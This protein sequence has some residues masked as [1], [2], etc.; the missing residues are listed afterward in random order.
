MR[1]YWLSAHWPPEHGTQPRFDIWVQDGHDDVARE[2]A[3]GD[4][5]AIY[6]GQ[7]GPVRLEKRP[8][9]RTYKLR[10]ERGKGGIIGFSK[11]VR[12]LFEEPDSRREE[13]ADGSSRWWRWHAVCEAI[14][15]E[16]FLDREAV[17]AVIGYEPGFNF[18]GFNAGRGIKELT[19]AQ[20]NQLL[21]AFNENS[22]SRAGDRPPGKNQRTPHVNKYPRGEG[23]DHKALKQYV[24]ENPSSVFPGVKFKRKKV[25]FPFHH[26]GDRIDVLLI[27]TD[28]RPYAIEIEVDV[29][30]DEIAGLLQAIKYKHMFAALR[31]R[32]YEEV[33]AVLVAYCISDEMKKMCGTYGITTIEISRETVQQKPK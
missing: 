13:Y 16:G 10:R 9:G 4:I 12:P 1:R 14:N 28:S 25:E 11:V 5:V 18:H 29:A 3:V 23:P 22:I 26:T 17:N 31:K 2:C 33:R 27:D 19:E 24:Y 6:Q 32:T 20:Y 8:D 21:D 30:D 15:T 7:S